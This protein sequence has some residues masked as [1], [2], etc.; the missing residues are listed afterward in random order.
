[1]AAPPCECGDRV[2]QHAL[3]APGRRR[4]DGLPAP[5]GRVAAGALI[6]PVFLIA[7]ALSA[8]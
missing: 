8:P 1:M 2:G 4:S 7:A 6:T 5:T 3:N